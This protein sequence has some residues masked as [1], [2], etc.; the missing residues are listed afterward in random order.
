MARF[1]IPGAPMR[2]ALVLAAAAALAAP[3]ARAVV[4][5][6]TPPEPPARFQ[7]ARQVADPL[8]LRMAREGARAVL[9]SG[10]EAWCPAG[11]DF[12]TWLRQQG[13]TAPRQAPLE[14]AP[15]AKNHG[16]TPNVW[17][18]NGVVVM[19]DDGTLTRHDRRI[20]VQGKTLVFTPSGSKYFVDDE[21]PLVYETNVGAPLF[22]D[23]RGYV[24]QAVDLTQMSFPFGGALQSRVWVSSNMAV[25]FAD[26]A[27]PG[28]AQFHFWEVI[29]DR[30]PRIGPLMSGTSLYGWNAFLREAADRT[31]ITWRAADG[32]WLDVDVQVVLF[33]DGRITM[34]YARTLGILHGSIVVVDGNATWWS[35]R[36]PGGSAASAPDEV[37]DVPPPDG[38]AIDIVE[39]R[40]FQVSG[41]EVLEIEVVTQAPLPAAT[42]STLQFAIELRDEPG[43]GVYQTV[44]AEWEDGRFNWTNWPVE[45]A[46]NVLRFRLLRSQQPL[47]D[48]D[49]QAVAWTAQAWNWKQAIGADL[50]WPILPPQALHRDFTAAP[51]LD[52]LA[53]PLVE[54]FTI[55]ELVPGAVYDVFM[56]HYQ[57]PRVDGLAIFQNFYTDIIFYA[58]AYSTVGNAGADGVG[59]G[60]TTDPESPALLHMN[61]IRYGWNSWDAGK[62]MVM[63]HE[64]GH[65]WLYFISIMENGTAG[66][67]L[68][69]G[70]PAGWV[71]TEA[72]TDVYSDRD[73]SCMG[74]SDWVDN[75]DGTF[76]SSPTFSSYGYSW[77]ELYLM[78]LADPTEVPDWFY[79]RN[80]TP[81]LPGAYWPPD[82]TTATAERVDVTLQQVIDAIGPRVPDT[83][84]SRK[85]FLVPFVL[86][87]RPGEWVQGDIDETRYQCDVWSPNFHAET[88][89]RGTVTCDRVGDR[90]PVVAI[91]DPPADLAIPEG[92]T[93]DLTGTGS[94]P[95]EDAVTLA[96]DFGAL[97]PGAAGPGP[98]PVTFAQ[99]GTFGVRLDG[100]DATGAVAAP[101]TRT[102]TVSCVT[103]PEVTSLR[104]SKS[105]ADLSL[106]FDEQGAPADEHVAGTAVPARPPVF[107][108]VGAG[109]SG[110]TIPMPAG[111]LAF[112]K[113]AA[114]S[115]PDCLGPW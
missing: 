39:V 8:D 78:G 36:A 17:L 105:G 76:T 97:A 104:V 37:T 29:A 88:L 81:A 52:P 77:H 71:A 63:N 4:P 47:A 56:R 23:Q 55:P 32:G 60:N 49:L 16:D 9:E 50:A 73:A 87:V 106:A 75:A 25:S 115:L 18:S 40:A 100:Q 84:T 38:P 91:T 85:D 107:A 93:L 59:V 22:A 69:D 90:P 30:T 108:E 10:P 72:A 3:A 96:W 20:D 61:T 26:P 43:G 67:P 65:H 15:L 11:E 57:D 44:W 111:R 98:H 101:D 53:G 79:L 54:S 1:L 70:H 14:P 114:R 12:A 113:V 109:A 51:F 83:S 66:K 86:V 42:D 58:G 31:V 82:N 102:I 46:G 5:A 103:P 27:A 95:D 45:V 62:A 2:L 35:D 68:G 64:F 41:S 110:L 7:G 33:A 13:L 6:Q 24:E 94:D 28:P 48:D 89:T 19:E 34:T 80:S 21:G 112:I 74:G 92:T 99:A